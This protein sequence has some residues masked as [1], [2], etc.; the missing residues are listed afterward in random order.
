[1]NKHFEITN[2]GVEY[3]MMGSENI[4]L[5]LQKGILLTLD[6]VRRFLFCIL[7]RFIGCNLAYHVTQRTE[8]RKIYI[9]HLFYKFYIFSYK[10]ESYKREKG[11]IVFTHIL[12]IWVY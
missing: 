10:K 2:Y 5:F 12:T 11:S 1:M 4:I 7:L 6:V 3:Y 8:T 9:L